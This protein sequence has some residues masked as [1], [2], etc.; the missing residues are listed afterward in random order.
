VSRKRR[1]FTPEFKRDVVRLIKET[2]RSVSEVSREMDLAESAV[3]RWLD[4]YDGNDSQ[5]GSGAISDAER[6]E[7]TRLRRR[8]RELEMEREILKK[9]AAFFAKEGQ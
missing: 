4:K 9:A 3:R 8:V 2:G 6:V 7:L 5:A 1:K